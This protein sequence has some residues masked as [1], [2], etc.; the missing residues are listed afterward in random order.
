MHYQIF[1]FEHDGQNRSL[2]DVGLE[3][4]AEGAIP[5]P[6]AVGPENRRGQ[7]FYW[8]PGP[9]QPEQ[10]GYRPDA[11]TW[12]E[13]QSA[14][15]PYRVGLWPERPTPADLERPRPFD[16]YRVPLGDGNPWI[17]PTAALLPKDYGL[18]GGQVVLTVQE[19]F[20]A[21]WQRSIDLHEL[22]AEQSNDAEAVLPGDWF[23]Y[24]C[25]ALALNY[26]ILPEIV[27]EL[28]LLNTRNQWAVYRAALDRIGLEAIHQA[29]KKNAAT[30]AS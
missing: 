6:P 22:L 29:R 17:V 28:Q 30:P 12:L 8:P 1:I 23:D 21:F 16:G 27:A 10:F 4:I 15:Q 11:Q 25:D 14:D 3:S 2:S 7:I 26:R 13:P 19:K 5:L 24:C 20:R 18:E 9:G